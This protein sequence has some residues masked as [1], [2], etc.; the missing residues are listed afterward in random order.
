M[1]EKEERGVGLRYKTVSS[2]YA[3]FFIIK[4]KKRR[5]FWGNS[6]F[7]EL[8]RLLFKAQYA[9]PALRATRGGGGLASELR[10][11]QILPAVGLSFRFVPR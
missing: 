7:E 10:F 5:V 3:Y 9:A 11:A 2:A 4:I 6:V 1:A 8:R